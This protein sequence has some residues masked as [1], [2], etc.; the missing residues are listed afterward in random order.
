M[1][2]NHMEHEE[3]GPGKTCRCNHHKVMPILAIIFGAAF[4]LADVNVLSWGFVNITWPIL[5]IIFGIVKLMDGK[6]NCCAK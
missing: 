1:D 6:C 4:L 5:L 2:N 3:H